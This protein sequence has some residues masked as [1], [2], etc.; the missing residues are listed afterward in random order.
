VLELR[1]KTAPM[2]ATREITD[3]SLHGVA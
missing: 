3:E 2:L 1:R